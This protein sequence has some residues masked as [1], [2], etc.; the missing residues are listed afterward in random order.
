MASLHAGRL[1]VRYSYFTAPPHHLY[2]KVLME[3]PD[4]RIPSYFA[5]GDV[6]T[7]LMGY[8]MMEQATIAALEP[9]LPPPPPQLEERQRRAKR[10]RRVVARRE[11]IVRS[12]HLMSEEFSLHD[13]PI[14]EPPKEVTFHLPK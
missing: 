8:S 9:P 11:K 5:V 1:H 12:L 7:E 13:P 4:G 6:H 10:I 2:C 14:L 3:G